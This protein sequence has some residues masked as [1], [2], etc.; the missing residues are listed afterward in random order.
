MK[1]LLNLKEKHSSVI[2]FVFLMTVVV[3]AACQS[4]KTVEMPE[5]LVVVKSPSDGVISKVL[6]SEGMTVGKDAGIVEIEVSGEVQSAPIDGKPDKTADIDLEAIEFK[7]KNAEREVE[8]TSVEVQ[9][10]ETLVASNSAPKSHLDAARADFQKAQE[11]L[12]N[13][14]EKEKNQKTD[15]LIKHSR[16]SSS[17]QSSQTTLKTVTA[18]VSVAG[19]LKVLNAR[20][21]QKVK[22][23][24]TLAT[25]SEN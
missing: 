1:V 20:I 10:V 24:Q 9:R 13:L 2:I 3:F 19:I 5:N 18:R 7:I 11:K 23:G 15:L 14:G 16:N 22:A 17:P 8:R 4:K 6:V 12:E 25:V 21:G